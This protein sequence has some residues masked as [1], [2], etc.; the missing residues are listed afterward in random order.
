MPPRAGPREVPPATGVLAGLL[1]HRGS[2]L[3]SAEPAFQSSQG[4]FQSVQP[5]WSSM[6]RGLFTNFTT[7]PRL[8]FWYSQLAFAVLMP[9]QPWLTFARPCDA[10]DQ[11]AACRNSPELVTRMAHLTSSMS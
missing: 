5:F 8:E 3:L 4:T 7:S 11:G 6:P 9:V 2:Q 1:N 10:A